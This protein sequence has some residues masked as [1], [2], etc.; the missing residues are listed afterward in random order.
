LT[1]PGPG[2]VRHPGLGL[3]VLLAA[4]LAFALEQTAMAPALSAMRVSLHT[5][6]HAVVWVLTSVGVADAVLTPVLGRLGDLMGRRR[7]L[8]W[9]LLVLAVG[10]AVSTFADNLTCSPAGSC[11]GRAAPSSRSASA[12]PAT[13]TRRAAA[14]WPSACSPR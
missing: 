8:I 14:R 3:A 12:S 6:P 13:C 10:G 9:S 5:S 11:R 4:T 2:H 7:V 1:T